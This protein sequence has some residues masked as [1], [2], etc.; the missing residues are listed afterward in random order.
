MKF[1]DKWCY[2]GGMIGI[3]LAIAGIVEAIRIDQ[4]I[5]IL[6]ALMIL[7]VG[8]YFL[9]RGRR[10]KQEAQ[11]RELQERL[12]QTTEPMRDQEEDKGEKWTN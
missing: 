8:V 11:A 2:Y 1:W 10:A 12:N 4:N 3:V 7:G 5:L 9:S 6:R